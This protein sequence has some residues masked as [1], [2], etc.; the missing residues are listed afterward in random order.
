MKDERELYPQDEPDPL[1]IVIAGIIVVAVVL[2]LAWCAASMANAAEP[3]TKCDY[4]ESL[5]L[6]ALAG[7]PERLVTKLE[8]QALAD[9]FN[10]MSSKGYL[11]GT[12]D[13]VDHVYI[14]K[15]KLMP[16]FDKPIDIL[17]FVQNS[18]IVGKIYGDA[19]IVEEML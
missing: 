14:I 8:G 3:E 4:P 12:L 9:F 15:G 2:F 17:F 16:G 11:T 19:K 7:E 6:D 13:L 5:I 10:K 18:C 1:R